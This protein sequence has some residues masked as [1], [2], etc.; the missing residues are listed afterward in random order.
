M[1]L[2]HLKKGCLS[3]G[4]VLGQFIGGFALIGGICFLS[5]SFFGIY[6]RAAVRRELD[7]LYAAMLFMQRKALIEGKAAVLA[8]SLKDHC[9]TADVK[10]IL[11]AGVRF[12]SSA[13]VYGPPSRPDKLIKDPI[14]W[15]K[16]MVTF[17]PDGTIVAGAL[18]LTDVRGSCIFALTCDASETTHIRRY[19]Y[20]G[21]WKPL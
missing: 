5:L 19:R 2:H 10:H 13:G 12:G 20:D 11:P 16:G 15:P 1:L 17:Y 9:Y 3:K 6:E 4:F 21:N 7:R 14:V 8:F 18:Y